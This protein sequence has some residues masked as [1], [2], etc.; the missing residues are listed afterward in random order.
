MVYGYIAILTDTP[1]DC[2]PLLFRCG[3]SSFGSRSESDTFIVIFHG[4]SVFLRVN[5]RKETSFYDCVSKGWSAFR[6]VQWFEL[7]G[8]LPAKYTACASISSLSPISSRFDWVGNNGIPG[9]LTLVLISSLDTLTW[10][11]TLFDLLT[12]WKRLSV[13]QGLTYSAIM[14]S[15]FFCWFSDGLTCSLLSLWLTCSLLSL[16][17]C[18]FV[19]VFFHDLWKSSV[20]Q[21]C[22]SVEVRFPR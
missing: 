8:G 6:K 11:S 3:S 9:V 17:A 15:L 18:L 5:P 2:L 1:Y 20:V 10:S 4:F 14:P 21:T 7:F 12:Q 16:W 13:S 19:D 22:S